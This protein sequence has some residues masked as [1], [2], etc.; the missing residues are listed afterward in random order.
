MINRK[1]AQRYAK[2]LMNIGQEDGKFD[3]YWK[4]LDAFTALF[5]GEEQLREVLSN[6]TFN[7]AR[8]QTIIKEIGKRLR[9]SSIIINFLHLLADKNRMRYLPDITALYRELADEAAGRA[10]VK[11]VTAHDLSK[12]KLT[13]LTNELQGLVGKQVVMEVATDP[14]LIGGVVA[15]IGG[16][17]YD[18]SVKTQLARLRETLAKG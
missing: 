5:Q 8:R 6:P 15:R 3:A 2:A 7:V 4:E 13:E 10:R 16:M 9:L 12:K 1:I 14:D 11:L 17:V 18:G